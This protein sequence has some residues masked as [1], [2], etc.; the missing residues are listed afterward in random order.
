MVKDEPATSAPAAEL[1]DEEL[2][3]LI[4]PRAWF[5]NQRAMGWFLIVTAMIGFYSSFDLSVE[6]VKKLEDPGRILS[7][8]FNPFFSCGSVMT[9]PGAQL[10]GFPNQFLGIAAFI[11]PLLLGVLLVSRTALPSWVMIGLNIG[12]LGGTALCTFLFIYSIF[13]I[14]VG[15]PWCIVVWTVTIPLFC[16]TTGYNTLTGAF[17]QGLRD[18]L[19]ARMFAKHSLEIGV[20]WMVIV[21]GLIVVKFWQ[22]FSNLF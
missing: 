1:S 16:V 3:E 8:D 10:F 14:G 13:I 4:R 12:L 18:S 15:C 22:F 17:G 21:Y 20:L 7:C 5:L 19:T 11:F 9:H 6:K 2:E